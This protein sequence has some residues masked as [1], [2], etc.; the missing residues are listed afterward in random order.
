M[1][2]FVGYQT[3]QGID[4]EA[5]ESSHQA[6]TESHRN[7]ENAE[8]G[9]E[10][11][12][13]LERLD[14]LAWSEYE[15]AVAPI[16]MRLSFL[17]T[18]NAPWVKLIETL[19]KPNSSLPDK[20]EEILT[21]EEWRKTQF[22]WLSMRVVTSSTFTLHTLSDYLLPLIYGLLGAFAFALRS[23]TEQVRLLLYTDVARMRLG[24]RL[25]LGA[26]GGLAIGWFLSPDDLS[27]GQFSFSSPWALAFLAGYSVEKLFDLL[28]KVV[29]LGLAV[30]SGEGSTKP[31]LDSKSVENLSTQIRFTE[32]SEVN[33]RDDRGQIKTDNTKI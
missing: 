1:Y 12:R 10:D 3:V 21:E 32:S 27:Q 14:A 15:S 20:A 17:E 7:F 19:P 6:C 28:D 26:L 11:E 13:V 31:V 9:G 25:Q 18:W 8:P 33:E 30:G 2:W 24:I 29:P 22:A 23:I 4:L 16:Q 5:A